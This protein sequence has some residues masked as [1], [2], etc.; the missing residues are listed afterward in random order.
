MILLFMKGEVK[1][2]HKMTSEII[3]NVE[4]VIMVQ[5]ANKIVSHILISFAKPCERELLVLRLIHTYPSF[6]FFP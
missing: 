6:I 5:L 1:I 3:N 2:T 4:G